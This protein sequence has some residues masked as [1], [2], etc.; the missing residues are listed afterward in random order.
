MWTR[1]RFWKKTAFSALMLGVP[2][3]SFPRESSLPHLV[4]WVLFCQR[5]THGGLSPS[6]RWWIVYCRKKLGHFCP[7]KFSFFSQRLHRCMVSHLLL[8]SL[9]CDV[10][11]WT[12]SELLDP[13]FIILISKWPEAT[14]TSS[15]QTLFSPFNFH[16]RPASQ[17]NVI[18]KAG[19]DQ[20]K[21]FC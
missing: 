21:W 2:E 11:I 9:G 7:L 20:M 5:H 6:H 4:E 12:H 19:E 13:E 1:N 14:E 15:E 18:L 8:L 16:R 17:F 3:R 10:S